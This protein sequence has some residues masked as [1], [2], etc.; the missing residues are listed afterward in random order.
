MNAL[1]VKLRQKTEKYD[2]LA[3]TSASV[4]QQ[5]R[6]NVS[7]L[8]EDEAEIETNISS[9]RASKPKR[10]NLLAIHE[11][12]N[13]MESARVAVDKVREDIKRWERDGQSI[14]QGLLRLQEKQQTIRKQV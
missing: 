1:E 4:E 7:D 10:D 8:I 3:A 2:D 9:A 14:Q 5:Y 12:Y 6:D 11:A 13:A